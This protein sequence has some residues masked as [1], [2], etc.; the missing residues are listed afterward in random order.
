MLWVVTKDEFLDQY[1]NARQA[2]GFS[3]ADDIA[4]IAEKV[5]EGEIEPGA[6]KVII[7]ARKWTA[8]RMAPKHHMPQ[9]LVNVESPNGT[10]TPPAVVELVA[11]PTPEDEGTD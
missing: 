4:M 9:S 2:G 6:A 5:L 8:E 7:D 1:R 11:K 3:H 10:M